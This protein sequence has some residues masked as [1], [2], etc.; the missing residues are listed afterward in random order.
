MLSKYPD[1]T[2][3]NFAGPLFTL[4]FWS[5]KLPEQTTLSFAVLFVINDK[6]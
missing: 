5:A 2:D 3:T 4:N 1:V 6:T